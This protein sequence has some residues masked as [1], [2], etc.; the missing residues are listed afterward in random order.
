MA[1]ASF[2]CRTLSVAHAA[3]KRVSPMF[4][5]ILTQYAGSVHRLRVAF[6][7]G[8]TPDKWARVWR[9][10]HPEIRLELLPIEETEQRAVLDDGT[11][12]LVLARLPVDRER[13]TPLHCVVLYEELPVVVASADHFVAA[14]EEVTTDDLA[15]EQL[16]LPERSGWAP[17]ARQLD[18]PPMSASEAVEV[19]AAGTGI[20]VLPMAVARLHH[21]KDTVQRPVI[22]LPPSQVALI[23]RKDDDGPVHQDFVGVTRGRRAS[24]GR[25]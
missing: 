24:S 7:P 2:R 1:I 17:A 12:D 10:R 5:K 16:A 22:D 3:A 25:R 19:A 20:A 15:D 18:F 11:A 8:V 14:A 4:P 9:E 21:R 23:W 6:V 13:P